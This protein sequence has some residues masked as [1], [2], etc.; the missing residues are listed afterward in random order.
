MRPHNKPGAARAHG[1]VTTPT[2]MA[3]EAVD[4]ATI[5]LDRVDPRFRAVWEQSSPAARKALSLYFLPH[6]SRQPLLQPKRPRVI[7]W[8][9]PFAHQ[10]TFSSGHRYCINVYTGCSHDCTY[11][12]AAS[13]EP[14]CASPKRDFGKLLQRDLEDLEQFRVPPAPVH[15]SNSTDPFQPL[16]LRLGHTKFT[17]EGLLR[18]RH[19]FTTLTVLTKNP[20]LA[21]QGDYLSLLRRLG[22]VGDDHP[23]KHLW[24]DRKRPALQ[25]EV[26]LAFWREEARAFWEKGAPSVAARIEGIRA[27]R[28]AGVPVV[29]RIDPLFPRSPVGNDSIATLQDFGIEE[30]QTMQDLERLVLLAKEIGVAHVVYSPVKIVW[31]RS[32]PMDSTMAGLKAAFQVMAAPEELVFRGGS[33]RLTPRVAALVTEPFVELCRKHGVSAKFCMK[34]L[35]ETL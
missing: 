33:W 20:L 15:I 34:N 28:Q 24:Q 13:Y 4:S 5:P 14:A 9:C 23:A 16:E 31:P 8:Y 25:V 2:R 11:C 35:V 17:L 29:L 19:R 26:S 32:R 3:D 21:A 7:K 12:Y 18:Y 10:H 1:V 22:D 30:A 6:S 27:L